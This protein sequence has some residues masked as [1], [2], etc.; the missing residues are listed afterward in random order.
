M[1]ATLDRLGVTQSL[2]RPRVSDDNPFSEAL[3]K[4]LKYCPSFPLNGRFESVAAAGQWCEEF[5]DWYNNVHLHSAI[6][7]VTPASRHNLKDTEI[8]A[9]R[10]TVYEE[11]KLK[12]P[13]RLSKKTRDWSRV[14]VVKPNSERSTEVNKVSFC[15]Q[16]S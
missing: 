16:A 10:H 9:K 2:S 3:F 7:W 11:A 14:D 6:N 15:F 1:C 8:L 5:V 4:T 13:N 12:Q